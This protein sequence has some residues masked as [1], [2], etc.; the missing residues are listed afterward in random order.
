MTDC[1]G[2]TWWFEGVDVDESQKEREVDDAF[3]KKARVNN[4]RDRNWLMFYL[5]SKR[6]KDHHFYSSVGK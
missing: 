2:V 3:E 5:F 1:S 6:N 4:G